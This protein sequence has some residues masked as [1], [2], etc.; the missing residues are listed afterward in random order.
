MGNKAAFAL[1]LALNNW[2]QSRFNG[3]MTTRTQGLLLEAWLSFFFV[4]SA[5]RAPASDLSLPPVS[6]VSDFVLK[7]W[8]PE[9]GLPQATVRAITQTRDGY[10]WVGTLNGLARFDG[11]RFRKY[12]AA[13]TPEL[14]SDTI[15]VLY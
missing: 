4:G 3:L 15:N 2:W 12:A 8:G 6:Q 5:I 7:E 10:L 11:V 13:N 9:H 1:Q 14:F